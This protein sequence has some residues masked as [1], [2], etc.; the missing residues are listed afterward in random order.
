MRKIFSGIRKFVV[1]DEGATAV[2]YGMM[3]G[4]IAV[5]I[6][7]AIVALGTQLNT[8]FTNIKNCLTDIATCA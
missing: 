7:V 8:L 5:V 3:I 4:L 1:Q 2:E 6:I